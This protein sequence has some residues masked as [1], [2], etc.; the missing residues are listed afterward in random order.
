M[1]RRCSRVRTHAGQHLE[2]DRAQ[3]KEV[4]TAVGL[5][6]LNLFG[7]EIAGGSQQNS[8]ERRCAAVA[9]Y[10]VRCKF[11]DPEIEDLGYAHPCEKDILG[12][13]ITVNEPPGVCGDESP[14]DVDADATDVRLGDGS[15]LESFPQRFTLEQFDDHERLTVMRADVVYLDDVRVIE[16]C[17]DSRFTKKTFDAQ[18]V[19]HAER[20]EHL[21][22]DLSIQPCVD[23]PIDDAHTAPS[24]ERVVSLKT[25]IP[26]RM[27]TRQYLGEESD[28]EA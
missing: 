7:R 2:Q 14:G 19:W 23:R 26:S 20:C 12:L 17:R 1:C 9:P 25:I 15:S 22:R 16:Q 27:A 24:D 3:S 21:Q 13:E 6:A 28:D 8:G 10:G 4:G 18:L 11:R 5:T